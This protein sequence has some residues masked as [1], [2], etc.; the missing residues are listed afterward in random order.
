MLTAD[1]IASCRDYVLEKTRYVIDTFGQR[2]PGSEAEARTQQLVAQELDACTDEEVHVESFLVAP[3]AFMGLQRVA[4]ILAIISAPYYW[5]SAAGAVLFS[6]AAVAVVYFEL[7]RYKQVIDLF[8]RKAT[9]FNVWAVQKPS[10]PVERRIILNAHPDAAYEW[11]WAY[12]VPKLF[13]LLTL[14]SIVALL[15]KFLT[16]LAFLIFGNGFAD[17]Y[18]G[19]WVY[20]G[21]AQLLLL[22]GALIGV[23]FTNFKHVSHGAN[24]NLTGTFIVTGLARHLRESGIQLKNTEVLYCI[25]GSEEAGLRGAKAFVEMHGSTLRDGKTIAVALDSFRDLDHFCV[26]NRDLNG[27]V[28]HDARVCKLLQDAGRDCGLELPYSSIYLGSSDG[29]A[30][31][32]GGIPSGM[33]GAM[34]PAPADWYHNRRDH[35]DNM[36]PECVEKA[37]AVV[38]AALKRYDEEGLPEM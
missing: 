15:G 23:F 27:T 35:Y 34:D 10:G 5:F 14:Y 33:L 8:A 18:S 9:S 11:R 32:Q 28:K 1:Q 24:D 29:T 7:I 6:G 21:L 38:A 2:P 31:T 3:K 25:T 13:P 22:P 16:D 12:H 26:Y 17:G 30:F 19:I 37:I 4:G 20:V 36:N